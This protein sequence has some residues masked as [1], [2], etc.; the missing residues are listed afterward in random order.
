MR[1]TVEFYFD[2]GNNPHF[3]IHTLTLMR[4]ATDMQMRHPD[5]FA[6]Y[7]DAMYRGISSWMA[8]CTGART[9]SI[10]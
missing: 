9:G 1:K 6:A 3:P 8:R 4:G 5:R 10:S 7:V 2:V